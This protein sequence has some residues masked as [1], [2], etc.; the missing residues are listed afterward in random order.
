[1]PDFSSA[2]SDLD[3]VALNIIV[4]E[5]SSVQMRILTIWLERWG[6][7]VH[8]VSKRDQLAAQLDEVGSDIVICDQEAFE[9]VASHPLFTNQD[10]RHDRPYVIILANPDQKGKA[11][12]ALEAGADDF[13]VLPIDA[14][15]LRARMLAGSR[16]RQMRLRLSEQTRLSDKTAAENAILNQTIMADLKQAKTIQ[17]SLLPQD[18]VIHGNFKISFF[19]QASQDIGGDF[20]GAFDNHFGKVGVCSLD[21]SGH[22]IS[23]A[24][25]AAV[26]SNYFNQ[27]DLNLNIA[28]ERRVGEFYATLPPEEV[29]R[30]LNLRLLGQSGHDLYL[31]MVYVVLNAETGYLDFVQAGHPHP[32]FIKSD[33][34]AYILGQGGL[35]IGLFPD[36]EV[37]THS[38]KLAPGEKFFMYSDGWIEA[39]DRLGHELGTEGLQHFLA[40]TL[41]KKPDNILNAL[42]EE[43]CKR[44]YFTFG[45]QDDVSAVMIEYLTN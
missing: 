13:L 28:M 38:V 36:Y 3:H 19:M 35:P 1:M 7:I 41:A 9:L 5:D 20:V 37:Q 15:E 17:E 45:A 39:T 32:L 44:G 27:T 21:I 18:D 33:N 6:H 22:G 26:V 11:L 25:M 8:E 24:L 42:Y 30:Q 12:Q 34:Q 14:Y 10:G 16:G 23:S 43:T 31:T 40:D 29:A 4:Q 2:E